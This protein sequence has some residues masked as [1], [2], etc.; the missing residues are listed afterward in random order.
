[1]LLP[2]WSNRFDSIDAAETKIPQVESKLK[3]T[4]AMKTQLEADVKQ[5]Q[6]DRAEAKAAIAKATTSLWEKKAVAEWFHC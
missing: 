3:E 5:A 1:M 2:N 4:S 6:S